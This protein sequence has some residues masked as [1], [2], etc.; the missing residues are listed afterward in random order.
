MQPN[1]YNQI[2]CLVTVVLETQCTT[3]KKRNPQ[4]PTLH[5]YL[6]QLVNFHSLGSVHSLG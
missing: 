2:L 4:L 5:T 3:D 6:I 1:F